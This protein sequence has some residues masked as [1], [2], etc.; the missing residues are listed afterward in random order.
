MY[1]YTSIH[2]VAVRTCSEQHDRTTAET[3]ETVK[4]TAEFGTTRA[5]Y[6]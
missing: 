2:S 6:C 5:L 1:Y 4:G 3:K